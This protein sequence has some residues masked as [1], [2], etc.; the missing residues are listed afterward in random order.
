MTAKR[1]DL[2]ARIATILLGA[3][4]LFPPRPAVADDE[5]ELRA[6]VEADWEIQERK[7]RRTLDS[8]EA[9]RDALKRAIL[10]GDDA[11]SPLAREVEGLDRL[12]TPARIDLYRKVRSRVRELALR[13]LGPAPIVFMK[14]RRFICQMLDEYLGYFYEEEKTVGGGVFVLEKPGRSLRTRDLLDKYA[15]GLTDRLTPR[16]PSPPSSGAPSGARKPRRSRSPSTGCSSASAAPCPSPP[17][18]RA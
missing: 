2:F 4:A 18:P 1:K 11:A 5:E 8:T 15:R 12:G 16:S 6:A 17:C 9:I 7:R 3:A 14:R 13:R 10:L